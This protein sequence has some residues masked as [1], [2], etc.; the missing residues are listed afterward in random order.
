MSP[1]FGAPWF[2]SI[3]PTAVASLRRLPHKGGAMYRYA[4]HIVDSSRIGE[5]SV[6]WVVPK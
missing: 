5:V 6:G 4:R 1:G 2:P 3:P